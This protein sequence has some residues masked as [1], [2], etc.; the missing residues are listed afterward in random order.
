MRD[1]KF[2]MWD[3]TKK[4]MTK[5]I[6]LEDMVLKAST[7]NP[8]TFHWNCDIPIMQY[9]GIDDAH[10]VGI[11][12]GDILSFTTDSTL[13]GVVKYTDRSFECE[14][15]DLD[16]D[17]VLNYKSEYIEIIGNIHENPELIK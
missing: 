14:M 3:E 10:G 17:D 12:E 13:T 5:S 8:K 4:T 16:Y 15:Y 9:I 2:R 11:F 7:R 1:I 6:L